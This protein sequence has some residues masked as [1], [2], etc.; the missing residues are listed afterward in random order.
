MQ[1]LASE[2]HGQERSKGFRICCRRLIIVG[3]WIAPIR[4]ILVR[5]CVLSRHL[6]VRTNGC[7]NSV[8]KFDQERNLANN[9]R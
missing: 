1:N 9:R 6:R 4:G 8:R 5:P 7:Y 3:V 2:C